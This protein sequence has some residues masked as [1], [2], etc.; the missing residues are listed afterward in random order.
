M[1]KSKKVKMNGIISKFKTSKK[2][3]TPDKKIS[4][5]DLSAVARSKN[6]AKHI[7][8]KTFPSKSKNESKP[9]PW[10]VPTFVVLLVVGLVWIVLYYITSSL[11]VPQFGVV[12]IVIGFGLL[13]IGFI[14]TTLWK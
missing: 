1:G 7:Q 6:P 12:N 2:L 10:L 3:N 9:R 14:L 8:K 11:P 5:K 13:V 4:K